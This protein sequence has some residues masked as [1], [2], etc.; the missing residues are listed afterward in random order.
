VELRS[1]ETDA[2]KGSLKTGA[3]RFLNRL[4]MQGLF[5]RNN[6]R[7]WRPYPAWYHLVKDPSECV[8]SDLI[9]QTL[10][11]TFDE[12]NIRYFAGSIVYYALDEDFYNNFD[13][14]RN[15]HHKVLDMLF[16]IE[17]TL[18]ETGELQP[19]NAHIICRKK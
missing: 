2:K 1:G 11:N 7:L 5:R 14:T 9:I 16:K 10:Q 6:G 8:H 15:S 4:W 3:V 18:I 12:I 13:T 17:D 19:D